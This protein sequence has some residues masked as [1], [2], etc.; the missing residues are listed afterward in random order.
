ME[1]V[2]MQPGTSLTVTRYIPPPLIAMEAPVAPVFQVYWLNVLTTFIN[3]DWPGHNWAGPLR[4]GTGAGIALSTMEAVAVQ[5]LPV[6]AVTVYVLGVLTVMLR[7]FCPEDQLK[8]VRFAGWAVSVAADPAHNWA[9]PVMVTLGGE[10]STM[11]TLAVP[12]QPVA[13]VTVTV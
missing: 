10:V 11:F 6:E 13:L 4:M 3:A 5:P 7:V 8:L 1:A 2:P 12:V 9:G